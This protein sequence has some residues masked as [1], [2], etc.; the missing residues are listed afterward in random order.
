MFLLKNDCL[1]LNRLDL[2]S[3]SFTF[4]N[5]SKLSLL[6]LNHDLLAILNHHTLVA[7]ANLLP[8][9]VVRST[10]GSV[11]SLHSLDAGYRFRTCW[12]ELE[13]I[14]IKTICRICNSQSSF[15]DINFDNRIHIGFLFWLLTIKSLH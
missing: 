9:E 2:R 3:R 12:D 1:L 8:S 14:E 4:G 7:L 10:C 13:A 15:S 6:L 5:E 11:I